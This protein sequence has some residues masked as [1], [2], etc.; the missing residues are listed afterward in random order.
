MRGRRDSL[1][2]AREQFVIPRKGN[3]SGIDT[4]LYHLSVSGTATFT[5]TNS[6]LRFHLGEP[7]RLRWTA[8]PNHSSS[9]WVGIYRKGAAKDRRFTNIASQGR[10]LGVYPEEWDGDLHS[11]THRAQ[12]QEDTEGVLEFKTF[13]KL[14]HRTGLYEMRLHHAGKHNVLAISQDIEIYGKIR[15]V[16]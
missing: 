3:T 10:W 15:N 14:P 4:D 1:L 8:P 11:P 12:D 13:N 5:S 6:P 2:E 9:D 16:Q 7:I